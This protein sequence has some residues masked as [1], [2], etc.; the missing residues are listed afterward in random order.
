MKKLK[1]ICELFVQTSIDETQQYGQFYK[2]LIPSHCFYLISVCKAMPFY[3]LNWKSK[4][5]TALIALPILWNPLTGY[6]ITE[7]FCGKEITHWFLLDGLFLNILHITD[8]RS[9]S[10]VII[11]LIFYLSN[12]QMKYNKLR[13]R[14][15][16]W[17]E[18]NHIKCY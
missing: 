14:K 8:T 17:Q 6:A 15:P 9:L 11:K 16:K 2:L 13:I 3:L 18:T 1:W 12:H 10:I 5:S 4:E 7:I